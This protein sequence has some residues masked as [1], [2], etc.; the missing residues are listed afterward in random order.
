MNKKE[1]VQEILSKGVVISPDLLDRLNENTL[2]SILQGE[3]K[4]EQAV[5]EKLGYWEID[6]VDFQGP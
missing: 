1:M 4:K 2:Q 6:P 3:N 5:A